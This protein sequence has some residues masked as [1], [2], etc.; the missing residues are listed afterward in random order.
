MR[1][2]RQQ[3]EVAKKAGTW[4]LTLPINP[5]PEMINFKIEINREPEPGYQE[6]RRVSI[7]A[8][9]DVGYMSEFPDTDEIEKITMGVVKRLDDPSNIEIARMSGYL[10]TFIGAPDCV[11][12]SSHLSLIKDSEMDMAESTESTT[13]DTAMY[14]L[15]IRDDDTILGNADYFSN[16]FAVQYYTASDGVDANALIPHMMA[17]LDLIRSPAGCMLFAMTRPRMNAF[18]KSMLDLQVGKLYFQT[19]R[20]IERLDVANDDPQPFHLIVGTVGDHCYQPIEELGVKG[21]VDMKTWAACA[22][23]DIEVDVRE[24]VH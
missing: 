12:M 14:L 13:H 24:T 16:F 23:P 10:S 19:L 20:S 7:V 15:D 18:E 9:L 6:I 8:T 4:F 2:M 21:I 5:E 3:V 22:Y 17:A 1:K 11:A